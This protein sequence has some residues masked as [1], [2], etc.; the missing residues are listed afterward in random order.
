MQNNSNQSATLFSGRFIRVLAATEKWFAFTGAACVALIMLAVTIQ[1]ITR[2]V[3]NI[4]FPGVYESTELLIVAV[5]Y[6]G[7]AYI[8]SENGHIKMDLLIDKLHGRKRK[9]LDVIILLLSIALFIVMT[10]KTGEYAIHEFII[11]DVAMG[12]ITWPLWPSKIF[13]PV[14]TALLCVRLVVHL[15]VCLSTPADSYAI[16]TKTG[17][18]K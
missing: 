13:V 11:G 15:I 12:I 1:V 16:N 10:Y 6:L 2:Y 17:D 8:E 3:F 5:V 18:N 14:G 4:Q 9:V 7:L